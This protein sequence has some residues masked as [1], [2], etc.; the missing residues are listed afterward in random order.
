[1]IDL[2]PIKQFS[3]RLAQGWEMVPGYDLKAGDY[4]VTMQSPDH[5]KEVRRNVAIAAA[6][7]NHDAAQKR[8]RERE[9]A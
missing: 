3:E 7:R 9:T 8:R 6:W 2:V 1:M 4:A 5:A